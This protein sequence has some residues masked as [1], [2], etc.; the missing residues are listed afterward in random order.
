MLDIERRLREG[1]ALLE[2]CPDFRLGRSIRLGGG[3]IDIEE[4]QA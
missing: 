1:E 3:L 2:E 4:I